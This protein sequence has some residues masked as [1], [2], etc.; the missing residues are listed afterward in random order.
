VSGP[1]LERARSV[2]DLD[3]GLVVRA[4][5]MLSFLAGVGV[6][7]SAALVALAH[8]DDTFHMNHVAGAWLWLAKDAA[9]GTLYPPLY[10]GSHFGGSR[11]MPLQI[12]VYA[13]AGRLSGDY[14]VAGKSVSLVLFALLL[15]LVYRILR[16]M[17]CPRTAAVAL[18]G[19]VTVSFAD[20]FAA[21]T[22]YGDTLPL[23]LQLAAVT[24]IATGT[25]PRFLLAAAVLC[26]LAFLTKLSAVWAPL[27]ITAWLLSREPRRA[28][29]FFSVY[30]GLTVGL[31]GGFD[32]WTDGRLLTNVHDLAFSGF[33]GPGAVLV[34]APKKLYDALRYKAQAGLLLVPVA[35]AALFIRVRERRSSPYALGL[36]FSFLVL[37]VVLAD[38]GTDYNHVLD[39][40]VLLALAAGDFLGWALHRGRRARWLVVGTTL[41]TL[42][43][44]AVSYRTGI[45]PDARAAARFAVTGQENPRLN[46]RRLDRYIF[47]SDRLLSEDP[48]VPL[49]MDRKPVITDGFMLLR[50]A[51]KHPAWQAALIGRLDR[52]QFDK[53]LL[54][55]KLDLADPWYNTISLGRPIAAAIA[56]NY[57]FARTVLHYG[58]YVPRPPR[59]R[60]C[61]TA[62]DRLSG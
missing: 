18:L 37:L 40:I 30:A 46:P 56:R 57:C 39:F 21:T 51:R 13:A 9:G 1:R 34:D 12:L 7:A 52:R 48:L 54:I 25:R 16:R 20:Y 38:V 62:N 5:F 17:D 19:V 36:V 60:R 26:A 49:L 10:D 27:A 45:G 59:R 50:I 42:I 11:Y 22:T 28:A 33:H 3:T 23:V 29:L 31:I 4:L 14:L 58:L 15:W 32:L 61:A 47:P 41:L 53:I 2:L 55:S 44:L 8:V 43:S 24:L 35:A 6:I